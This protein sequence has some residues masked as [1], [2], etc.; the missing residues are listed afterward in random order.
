MKLI[1]KNKVRCPTCGKAM[2]PAV[3]VNDLYSKTWLQ[4]TC[5]TFVDTYTPLPHQ[6]DIHRDSTRTIGVFGG[7]GSGKT[8]CTLKDDEKHMLSTPHGMT[9]VGSAVLSQVELSYEKDFLE[10][11]P[12]AFV[13]HWNKQKKVF[14]LVNGHQ[15]VIKSLYEEGLIRSINLT[16]F[17]IVEASEVDH[18]I[19]TQ[20][21]ARFRNMAGTVPVLDEDGNMV[22]D[23]ASNS[24]LAASDWRK[25]IVESNPSIGWIRDKFLLTSGTI[26][27]EDEEYFISDP[28]YN[29]SS[30]ILPT[31]MNLFLPSDYV[32]TITKG[33]PIWW[34]R[35]FIEGSFDY[36]EGMVYP[37]VQEIII[38]D[39]EVPK[40]WP[41]LIAMDYGIND[42]TCFL[43]GA[44]DPTAGVVFIF[45]EI[46]TNNKNY[47]ELSDLYKLAYP[48]QVP[49]DNLY[50]QPVMDAKSMA[51]RNDYNLVK[52]GE[53]FESVGVR[54]SPAQMELNTRI[55][56]VNTLINEHKIRILNT[57]KN[58]VREMTNYKFP[59]YTSDGKSKGDKPI[60]KNNHAISA[61]E[62][63]VME[64]PGDL[65]N[66]KSNYKSNLVPIVPV[67]GGRGNP[68]I[69]WLNNKEEDENDNRFRGVES[70]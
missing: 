39:I 53:L 5:N 18:E 44:V 70:W 9:L 21:L 1:N 41:R 43:F 36:A 45:H 26:F 32:E 6:N 23:L 15:L 10:D 13:K 52:I 59:G 20:L 4:C 63:L 42:E 34:I 48:V 30:Y 27:S 22:L 40:Q 29:K 51:R 37:R 31:K 57:C 58:L 7:Y 66:M 61:L 68:Y 47:K 19:F 64:L 33:K 24:F 55:L 54:F 49:L 38:E 62:F 11:F 28:D 67:K 46:Y 2:T 65:E 60:D 35:R 69:P 17:H 8:Y 12:K 16:R 56:K 3:T 50:T 25:G 14:T